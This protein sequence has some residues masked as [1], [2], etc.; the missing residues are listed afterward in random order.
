MKMMN[1]KTINIRKLEFI[2]DEEY[3]SSRNAKVMYYLRFA[4]YTGTL[5]GLK[6]VSFIQ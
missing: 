5:K 2:P 3:P 6:A 4:A 1:T